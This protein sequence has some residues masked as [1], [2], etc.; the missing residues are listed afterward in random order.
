[1]TVVRS[2]MSRSIA[3]VTSAVLVAS[4]L[5]VASSSRR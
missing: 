2:F 1:M 5:L 3:T 4:R